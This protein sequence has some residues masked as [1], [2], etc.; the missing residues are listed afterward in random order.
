MVGDGLSELFTDPEWERLAR[1][2]EAAAAADRTRGV[3]LVPGLTAPD[4]PSMVW[5]PGEREEYL[6]EAPGLFFLI[7]HEQFLQEHGWAALVRSYRDGQLDYPATEIYMFA[8]APEELV[9]PLLGGWQPPL[10]SSDQLPCLRALL[11]RFELDVLPAVLQVAKLNAY[12]HGSVLLPVRSAAVAVLMA[13]WLVRLKSARHIAR[14]WFSRHAL[15]AVPL[16]TP[17]AL[18][19]TRVPREKASAALA[20]IAAECGVPEVVAAARAHGDAAAAGI[21]QV[22]NAAFD[23]VRNGVPAT[24]PVTPS[25]V[26]WLDRDRLPRIL[27]RD[28]SVLPPVAVERLLGALELAPG[29]TWLGTATPYPGLVKALEC[30]D[31]ASLAAFGRSIFESWVAAGAPGRNGWV[32]DQFYWLADEESTRRLGAAVLRWPT[33]NSDRQAV[34]VLRAIGTDTALAELDRISRRA[35]G[36]GLRSTAV[37]CL[38]TAARERGL[39][40]EEIADRLVPDL[41]LDANGTLVLDYGPRRFTVGFDE[42]LMPFVIDAAG[43]PRKALP[44]PA[45]ADDSVLAPAAYQRFTELKKLARATAADQIRRLERA[46][47]SGRDWSAADFERYLVSPPL[48]RHITRRLIWTTGDLAF[49]IAED[50]TLADVDDAT[51]TLPESARVRIAHPLDLGDTVQDWGEVLADYEITQPFRQLGR[52][53]YE[54]TELERTSRGIDRI[55][56]VTVP[57][58]AILGLLGKGWERGYKH[59]GGI[60]FEVFRRIDEKQSLTI[61]LDPGIVAGGAM[62]LAEQRITGIYFDTPP[63]ELDPVLASELLADLAGLVP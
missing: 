30:C 32:I 19:K 44:K 15:A 47:T 9:R 14:A 45:A 58:G 50:L 49:R 22:L 16:L 28:G 41:G 7:Y 26:P 10:Y 54:L 55:T 34:N 38:T 53:V 36:P 21:Q 61:G 11:A 39:S 42:K 2:F 57:V 62:I 4:T 59:G 3:P 12:E 48:L 63:L 52:A 29:V 35:K 37:E 13:D 46:M 56:G 6:A 20:F 51:V 60:H 23:R 1:A 18:G 43:K 24:K 8:N 40:A 25:G 27:L 5:E 31:R 17:D 33:A